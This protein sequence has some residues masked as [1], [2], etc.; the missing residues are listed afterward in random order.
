[1]YLV[2]YDIETSGLSRSNHEIIQI[3][4]VAM[5]IDGKTWQQ[6]G[7]F[8]RKLKFDLDKADPQA[9][10]MNCY[11][12]EVWEK[13]AIDSHNA[14]S[15]FKQWCRPYC[16]VARTAKKSG[17]TFQ[18]LRTGGHNVLKFDDEF[19][20]AWFKKHDEFC[21]FDF[22]EILDTLQ[23]AKWLFNFWYQDY[24]I[25]NHQLSTLC[26]AYGVQLE[27]AHDALSDILANARLAWCMRFCRPDMEE[28]DR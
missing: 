11:D 21:P 24:H 8:E 16:D 26:K 13:E 5:Q 2:M 7:A 9:L 15:A 6:V 22:Q 25:E 1:M 14:L 27:D 20:R 28:V 19:V 3:A 17:R 10:E 12:P 18:N 23:L 4:A